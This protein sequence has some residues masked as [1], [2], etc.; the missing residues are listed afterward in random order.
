MSIFLPLA[1]PPPLSCRPALPLP[2]GSSVCGGVTETGTITNTPTKTLTQSP[3]DHRCSSLSLMGRGE[4]NN[5][6]GCRGTPRHWEIH[7]GIVPFTSRVCM[8]CLTSALLA[9]IAQIKFKLLLI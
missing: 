6:A 2:P 4:V 3:L 1:S 7:Y 8:L 5:L 9:E